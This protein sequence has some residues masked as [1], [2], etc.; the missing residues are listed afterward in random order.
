[1]CQRMSCCAALARAEAASASVHIMRSSTS[2]KATSHF[3]FYHHAIA[4]FESRLESRLNITVRSA[5]SFPSAA[6]T[7]HKPIHW[8]V[9]LCSAGAG[10]G[11][12][13]SAA[14][15]GFPSASG[16]TRSG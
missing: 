11:W 2:N 10:F 5:T 8:T 12:V 4:R 6:T 15:L 14:L 16:I 3:F 7:S 1:M 13:A 9:P